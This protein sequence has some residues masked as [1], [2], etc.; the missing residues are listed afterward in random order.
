VCV[1]ITWLRL[2]FEFADAPVLVTGCA[3]SGFSVP[4]MPTAPCSWSGA[5]P[6]TQH[7]VQK[8]INGTKYSVLNRHRKFFY[9]V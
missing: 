1:A 3:A 8:L 5:P 2:F 6:E 9:L 7:L 4:V